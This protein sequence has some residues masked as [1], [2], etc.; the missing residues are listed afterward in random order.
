VTGSEEAPAVGKNRLAGKVALVTGAG[1]AGE[2]WGNGKATAVVYAREGARVFAVDISERAVAETRRIIDAEGG[3]CVAHVADVSRADQ[4]EAM[5]RACLEAFGR[6]DVLHNNVGVFT[7]GTPPETGEDEWDR[8][9]AVNVKSAFLTCRAVLPVMERQG[10]G[11]IV[12]ISTLSSIRFTGPP[13][14]TYSAS[15]AAL[16]AFTQNIAIQY[17]A[18]GI[19]ANCVLPGHLDTPLIANKLRETMSEDEVRKALEAR[20][21]IVPMGRLGTAWDVAHASLFLAS[22]EAAFITGI[23]LVVDGGMS[24]RAV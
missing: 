9:F 18:K 6:I 20:H 2:G 4:V 21:R 19:R 1:T 3:R 10:G 23:E 24:C 14:G 17:A 11:A 22:D 7:T 13:T 12:N 15:K 16:N 8:V 5:V